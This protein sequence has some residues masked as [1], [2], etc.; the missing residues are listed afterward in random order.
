MPAPQPEP[1]LR[2]THTEI[3]VVQRAVLHALEQAHEDVAFWCGQL[4][5]PELELRQGSSPSVA[6]QMRHIA[7]SL[8]RLFTYAE[9]KALSE[10][11]LYLLRSEHEP[12]G[13]REDLFAEFDR[14]M[15]TAQQRLLATVADD[16]EIPRGIGRAGIPTTL[17]GILIHS[18]EHTQRHTG[19]AITTVKMVLNQR[20]DESRVLK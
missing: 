14:A 4:T 16:L 2:V 11:Q 12:N 13:L 9:G 20:S 18:A 10:Q 5:L 3:P 17:G 7:R 19:Q 1:W 8:D 6:F 15:K